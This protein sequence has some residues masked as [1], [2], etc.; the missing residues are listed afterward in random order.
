MSQKSHTGAYLDPETQD[1]LHKCNNRLADHSL[2]SLLVQE[3]RFERFSRGFEGLLLDFTR[4]RLDDEA[5]G[6]LL[7]AAEATGLPARRDALFAGEHVNETEDRPALHM[8]LRSPEVLDR[9]GGDE[10]QRVRDAMTRL[11]AFAATFH[12]GTVNF[13]SWDPG[14]AMAECGTARVMMRLSHDSAHWEG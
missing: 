5:L 8:A 10:A 6:Q 7:A 14:T 9:V 3:D 13:S 4:V 1:L 2:A 11:Y 12:A